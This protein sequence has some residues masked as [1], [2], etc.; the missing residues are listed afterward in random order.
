MTGDDDGSQ[1]FVESSEEISK[2][3]ELLKV[4]A[5]SLRKCILKKT[6]KYPG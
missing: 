2:A 6:V 3:A 1:A 5:E 4:D